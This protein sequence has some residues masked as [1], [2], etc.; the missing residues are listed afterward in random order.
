MARFTALAPA[1][2][3]LQGKSYS[4]TNSG[5]RGR[6]RRRGRRRNRSRT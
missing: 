3:G 5:K 1:K 6:K 2:S 4:D